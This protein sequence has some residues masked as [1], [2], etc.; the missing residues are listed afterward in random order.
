MRNWAAPV[1]FVVTPL[2]IRLSLPA[3]VMENAFVRASPQA[4]DPNAVP[5]STLAASPLAISAPFV[6]KTDIRATPPEPARYTIYGVL[7]ELLT[8]LTAAV[9]VPTAFGL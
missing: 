3:L 7:V 6:P 8:M 9:C 1:P 5:F 4:R 2:M